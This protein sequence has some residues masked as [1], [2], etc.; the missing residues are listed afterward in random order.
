MSW[1]MI[2]IEE[3]THR[4][5]EMCPVL[6][7]EMVPLSRLDGRVLAEDILA[8][9]RHKFIVSDHLTRSPIC[10]PSLSLIT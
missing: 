9:V 7:P 3:A 10:L 4:A 6:K 1:P 5:L 8:P 2:S